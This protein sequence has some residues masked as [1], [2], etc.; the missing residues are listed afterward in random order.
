MVL[1][2]AEWWGESISNLNIT[3][4]LIPLSPFPR[5]REP[6]EFKYVW[7]PACA[8]MT[9]N[10]RF[11]STRGGVPMNTKGMTQTQK[12]R[13]LLKQDGLVVGAGAHDAMTA[14]IVEQVGFPLCFVTGA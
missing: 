12:L 4:G 3:E 5:R 7:M 10:Q 1:L 11:L 6:R 14:H 9:I 2:L 13:E 8:G